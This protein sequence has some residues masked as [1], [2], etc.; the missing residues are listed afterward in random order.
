MPTPPNTPTCRI[1]I[2]FSKISCHVCSF[3]AGGQLV[4][5]PFVVLLNLGIF[6]FFCGLNGLRTFYLSGKFVM[7]VAVFL[8][9]VSS[10]GCPEARWVAN[11]LLHAWTEMQVETLGSA[12][13]SYCFNCYQNPATI[14]LAAMGWG[15]F[16]QLAPSEGLTI[17]GEPHASRKSVPFGDF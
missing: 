17:C 8:R 9:R 13:V 15:C 16:T 7:G 2:L 12:L 1:I 10:G 11:S 5:F 6:S 4:A 3:K 14:H